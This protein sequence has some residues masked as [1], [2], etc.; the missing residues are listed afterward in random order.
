MHAPFHHGRGCVPT[1][2]VIVMVTLQA[3]F[4]HLNLH[5]NILLINDREYLVIKK[6]LNIQLAM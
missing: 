4:V 6:N 1:S 3:H 5:M 2:K